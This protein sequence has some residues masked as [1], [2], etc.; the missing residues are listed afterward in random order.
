MLDPQ[1]RKRLHG[2]GDHFGIEPEQRVVEELREVLREA[3]R[4]LKQ[5]EEG[6]VGGR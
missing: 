2:F 1:R 5:V 6:N 3:F 4:L